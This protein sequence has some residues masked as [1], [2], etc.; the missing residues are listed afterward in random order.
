MA[1]GATSQ[2]M[3]F[4][5]SSLHSIL[6][7]SGAYFKKSF[8]TSFMEQVWPL[9]KFFLFAFG[10][11]LFISMTGKLMTPPWESNILFCSFQ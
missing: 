10:K 9:T 2:E 8:L 1:K 11:K 6:S 7:Q 4:S 3:M 5:P